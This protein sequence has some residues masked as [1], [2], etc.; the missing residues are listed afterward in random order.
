MKKLVICVSCLFMGLFAFSGI[1]YAGTATAGLTVMASIQPYA[2]VSVSPLDF[3]DLGAGG[4]YATATISVWA[5]NELSY[6]IA[7]GGG[8]NYLDG[9]RRLANETLD[10]FIPYEL[11]TEEGGGS[12]WGDEGYGDTFPAPPTGPFTGSGSMQEYTVYG[13]INIGIGVA[14]DYYED[15]VL[16]T[17]NY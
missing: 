11:S 12:D 17:V 1:V 8:S 16:V 15:Y 14:A 4:N 5:T 6:N 3:G 7:L 10:Q 9:L 13:T 2:A